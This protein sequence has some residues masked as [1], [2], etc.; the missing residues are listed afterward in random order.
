VCLSLF[1]LYQALKEAFSYY[2]VI[3]IGGR[4]Q[5]YLPT[6]PRLS[7]RRLPDRAPRMRIEQFVEIVEQL[8]GRKI[9]N[10]AI[11]VIADTSD[12][13]TVG[14]D[15]LWPQA[16][17]LQAFQMF[18]VILFELRIGWHVAVHCNLL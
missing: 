5:V 18:P 7:M 12:R 1:A 17:K 4:F 3:L 15:G 2:L 16:I 13:S 11:K 6:H 14:I 9:V 10:S 8:I